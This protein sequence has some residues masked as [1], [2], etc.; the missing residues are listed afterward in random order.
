MI[1]VNKFILASL[2]QACIIVSQYY[3]YLFVIKTINIK[4]YFIYFRRESEKSHKIKEDEL[5]D[6]EGIDKSPE[7]YS[8]AL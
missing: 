7:K 5:E 2:N 1:Y 3:S 8:Y 6:V 4:L